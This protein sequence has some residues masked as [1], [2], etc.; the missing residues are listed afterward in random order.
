MGDCTFSHCMEIHFRAMTVKNK[1]ELL[2]AREKLIL[3]LVAKGCSNKQIAD[4]LLISIETVKNHLKN[5]Y[6][7]LGAANRIDALRRAAF[8]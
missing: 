1:I 5:I 4:K 6:R 7:K 3:K 8:I 2:T